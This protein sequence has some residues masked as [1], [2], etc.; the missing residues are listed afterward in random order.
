MFR[1]L[2][3]CRNGDCIDCISFGNGVEPARLNR[4]SVVVLTIGRDVDYFLGRVSRELVEQKASDVDGRGNGCSASPSAN[5]AGI[6]F[7]ADH[8][9]G[10][11][12]IFQPADPC[13]RQHNARVPGTRPFKVGHADAANVVPRDGRYD[14]WRSERCGMTLA[15]Q[16]GNLRID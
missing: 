3:F 7:L 2:I 15:L 4:K 10:R 1:I 9:R 8:R 6:A 11:L 16:V 12:G 13:P 5:M 14:L